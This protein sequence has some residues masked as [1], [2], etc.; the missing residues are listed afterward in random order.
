M[1]PL[2]RPA[3]TAAPS[4]IEVVDRA[5][6]ESGPAPKDHHSGWTSNGQA[7][8]FNG[9]TAAEASNCKPMAPDYEA[10]RKKYDS[11]TH[12]EYANA[13]QA[14]TSPAD[15]PPEEKERP[16]WPTCHELIGQHGEWNA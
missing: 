13:T 15:D 9:P 7:V 14:S 2:A 10:R 8:A 12:P 3:S 5:A 6:T 1:Q 11:V 4:T 16:R